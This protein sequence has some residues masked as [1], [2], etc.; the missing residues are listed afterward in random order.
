LSSKQENKK[1]KRVFFLLFLVISIISFFARDNYRRVEYLH[2]EVLAEPIQAEP[3]YLEK[4]VFEKNDYKYEISPLF[5]YEIKGLIV[6]KMDYTFFSIYKRDSVFPLDLCIIWGS[7]LENGIYKNKNLK[8]SQDSRFCYFRWQG[9]IDF[10]MG[11]V[12]NNHL[13][14]QSNEVEKKIKSLGVGDQ[15]RVKGMLVDV[16][17]QNIGSPGKFDPEYFEWKSSVTR[18]DSGSGACETIFVTDIELL[19]KADRT[20]DILFRVGVYGVLG[21]FLW[22]FL[23]FLFHLFKPLNLGIKKVDKKKKDVLG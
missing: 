14:V 6:H 21:V 13:V 2:P 3:E 17:A 1:M 12:S 18:K 23:G 4:F 10:N 20:P 15:V 5:D 19:K 8:F 7:N 11:E 22:G 9:D 16:A